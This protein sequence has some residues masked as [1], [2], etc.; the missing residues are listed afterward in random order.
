MK[1]PLAVHVTR[2]NIAPTRHFFKNKFS[3]NPL[4]GRIGKDR[5]P[6]N[7]VAFVS[8]INSLL[9]RVYPMPIGPVVAE[10]SSRD[11]THVCLGPMSVRVF[12]DFA[13]NFSHVK[14]TGKTAVFQLV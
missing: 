7:G 11:G 14:A 2:A 12:G 3:P 5:A 1:V 9:T 10:L 4:L 8:L 13:G 6:A